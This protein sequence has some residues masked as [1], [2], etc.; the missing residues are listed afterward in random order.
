MKGIYIT[1]VSTLSYG[2]DLK[3]VRLDRDRRMVD[4]W[5]LRW[6]LSKMLRDAVGK[7]PCR[8]SRSWSSTRACL[9]PVPPMS[10]AR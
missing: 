1:T 10:K 3:T 6:E 8:L 7:E 9:I 5:D 2:Y 4:S